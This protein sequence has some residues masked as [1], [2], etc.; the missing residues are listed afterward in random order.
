VSIVRL[1]HVDRFPDRH[2]RV[3]YYFRRGKGRRI[4]LPGRPG[5]EE[6]M[7]A[8]Q[9]ALDGDEPPALPK[10][11][12]TPGTFDRLV[13]NY[14][15]S[16]DYLHL[17]PSTR[18]TYRLVIER[19]LREEKIGHRLVAQMTRQHVQVIVGR[20]AS[21]PGAANDVLKKLKI[22]L[23]FA[24]DHGW[25]KD[26][27]T[28]RIKGFAEG[29]F[30][31]W[32]DEEI[33]AFERKW[34]LGTRERTAFALLLFTG[35]RASDVKAMSWADVVEDSIH[36]AQGKTGEKLWI[37]MHLELQQALK[38]RGR[39]G[40]LMLITGFGKEF[41]DKGFSNFMAD[42]IDQAGLPDRCVTHG[43]RKAAARRLAE[44]GCSTKEIAAI[45]GHTTLKE[46][47]RYTRAA[48][49][50]KL[51]ASAMARLTPRPLPNFPN[52][53]E[54]LGKMPILV[55]NVTGMGNGYDSPTGRSAQQMTLILLVFFG[56]IPKLT[57]VGI[58]PS[59][60][61]DAQTV[62][63]PA[64]TRDDETIERHR[65]GQV[66]MR[67]AKQPEA[68]HA[69][70]STLALCKFVRL[71]GTFGYGHGPRRKR[72]LTQFSLQ[73]SAERM[74]EYPPR[75]HRIKKNWGGRKNVVRS[76]PGG[77]SSQ[78]VTLFEHP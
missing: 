39:G 35:Q 7:R 3:R 12:G 37:P 78:R 10:L 9:A 50:R 66:R 26:D 29:E 20:R 19:L 33:E 47:E 53:S 25:R 18:R 14:F 51:A 2:G 48:E 24:I 44:A 76:G 38:S 21:T 31:T 15:A 77:A 61:I 1:K 65:N 70:D 67:G 60:L 69:W 63:R 13:Q 32:T 68:R 5:T 34:P 4:P 40:G 71:L 27:P 28:L 45:T 43:L 74:R 30:H 16:T 73:L 56:R 57:K 58:P 6:F 72:I 17:A 11:R 54:G 36:V 55:R 42:R 59:L 41:S 49:Q 75:M 64:L 46:I 22:L 23:H 8:Y 52:R 62:G